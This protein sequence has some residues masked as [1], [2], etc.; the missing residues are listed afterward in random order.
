M[1]LNAKLS[2][3]TLSIIILVVIMISYSLFVYEKKNRITDI[4]NQQKA[5]FGN[6]SNLSK[7]ALLL[8]DELLLLN[9]MRALKNTYWG[10]KYINFISTKGRVLY[11]DKENSSRAESKQYIDRKMEEV[12]K[13]GYNR[14]YL[15]VSAPVYM[16]SERLG[17]GQIGFS[18]TD[19]NKFIAKSLGTARKRIVLI[20]L[21]ALLFGLAGSLLLSRTIA[22]PI[23]KLADGAKAIGE[24]DFE[25]RLAVKSKDELGML[26][27]EFNQ[28]AE[29]FAELDEAKD[30]FV[31]AV[32]HELRTPLAAIEGYIDFLMEAGD[33]IPLEKR[34]KALRIMKG[35][36]QRLSQ[37]INDVLDIAKIK[38]ARMSFDIQPHSVN[39]VVDKVIKLLV[40]V[41]EQ[42]DINLATDIQENI[43][44]IMVDDARINQVLTNL[45]GNA[46]KFT[47]EKGTITIGGHMKDKRNVLI[48]VQ[49]TGPGI[50]ED[51]LQ[52]IFAQFEQSANAKN[53][54]GPKGTG[55]GLAIA[56]GIV[57][58]H[59]GRIWV[60]SKV[61]KGTSF[62]FTIPVHLGHV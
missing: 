26:A 46:L 59:G 10:I 34:E 13:S 43:P 61:G 24:G 25:T 45:I 40:S 15:E 57:T 9:I 1:K 50:P 6:F 29:K 62:N 21:V 2:G 19:Y 48:S 53:V 22:V 37:F 39:S 36:S 8:R 33:A 44:D 60:E 14:E 18:K 58:S 38:S 30:D 55:L 27:A 41:A 3:F 32:S 7:E 28:M 5:I 56:E 47:P 17:V 16:N 35:S 49:D 42:K 23:K 20:S 4:T 31:N 12:Y 11:T 54:R 52:R 51:D